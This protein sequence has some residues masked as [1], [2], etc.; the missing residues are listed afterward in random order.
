M[1]IIHGDETNTQFP[2]LLM[3][4]RIRPQYQSC[5]RKK[6]MNS[7]KAAVKELWLMFYAE[8]RKCSEN[9]VKVK[10]Y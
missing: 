7:N 3:A 8:L 4:T 2:I 5:Y 6:S 10:L 1:A 9:R